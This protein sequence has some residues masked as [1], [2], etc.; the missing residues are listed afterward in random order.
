MASREDLALFLSIP[1]DV[2]CVRGNENQSGR[3]EKD[4]AFVA[5][6]TNTITARP[7]RMEA[8]RIPV[9]GRDDTH[10]VR[11]LWKSKKPMDP[12]CGC[13]P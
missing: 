1:D 3:S 4:A 13:P 7:L 8:N 2:S 10:G 5:N 11:S 12:N 6:V 9:V